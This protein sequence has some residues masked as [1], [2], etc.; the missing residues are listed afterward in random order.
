MTINYCQR[1]KEIL[2]KTHV[3]TI[4]ILLK[5]KMRKI[6]SLIVSRIKIFLFYGHV[7][8]IWENSE[9]FYEF[10]DFF[11]IGNFLFHRLV[12]ELLKIF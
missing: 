6:A 10:K 1:H 3:K 8:D 4:K 2:L 5:K 7:L 11:I 12:P 9:I